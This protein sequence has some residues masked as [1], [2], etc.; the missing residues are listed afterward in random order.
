[1]T[2]PGWNKG[3]KKAGLVDPK[4]MILTWL[5]SSISF[6]SSVCLAELFWGKGVGV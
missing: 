4:E 1:M 2:R 5:L 3:S 6:S